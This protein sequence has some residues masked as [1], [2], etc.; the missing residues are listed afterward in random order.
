MRLLKHGGH[1]RAL[2]QLLL[3][4]IFFGLIGG[5]MVHRVQV[6]KETISLRQQQASLINDIR[7]LENEANVLNSEVS[8]LKEAGRLTRAASTVYKMYSPK[9]EQ[10]IRATVKGGGSNE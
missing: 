6:K 7:R 5:A 8:S 10:I 3:P 4:V 9:D 1:L 2:G